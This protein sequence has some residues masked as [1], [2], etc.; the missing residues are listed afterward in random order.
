MPPEFGMRQPASRLRLDRR[1]PI[2]RHR[3]PLRM[4]AAAL[5]EMSLQH[6]RSG[7]AIDL[8]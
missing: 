2:G 1:S 3:S 5:A 6:H 7:D 4:M 8:S